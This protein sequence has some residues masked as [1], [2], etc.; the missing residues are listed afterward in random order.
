MNT[1]KSILIISSILALCILEGCDNDVKRTQEH[2]HDSIEGKK[3][4]DHS[5]E[6]SEALENKEKE[7]LNH[8]EHRS[9]KDAFAHK[10]IILLEDPYL[11][12]ENTR[13]ELDNII[14]VYLEL[15]DAFIEAD[16]DEI[17]RLATK[18]KKKVE[19]VDVTEWETNGKTAWQ[20]HASLYL[21]KLSEMIHLSDLSEK[22]SY[23]S[24]LSEVIYCTIKS[25]NLKE[26]EELYTAYCPMAFDGK[27]AYW[28]SEDQEIRNPY[29]GKKMPKCGE[30]KEKL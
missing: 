30:I 18:M 20:Q 4:K 29:F 24:H 10:D 9:L 6:D 3:M 5:Y 12:A 19:V 22:R 1:L 11:A 7:I 2:K 28:I 25:F 8:E 26:G 13:H 27:G 17:D 16:I 15:K 14:E 21:Q 23:F